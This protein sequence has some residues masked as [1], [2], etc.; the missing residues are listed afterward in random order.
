MQNINENEQASPV[1][2]DILFQEVNLAF[3][4]N[5]AKS[6]EMM[7]ITSENS[8]MQSMTIPEGNKIPP[9]ESTSSP[10]FPYPRRG[11]DPSRT[12][13]TVNGKA[14][15]QCIVTDKHS[16]DSH[17]DAITLSADTLSLAS[18]TSRSS[19][20]LRGVSFR[21]SRAATW[22]AA[23]LRKHQKSSDLSA[24]FNLLDQENKVCHL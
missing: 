11:T 2:D 18:K 1:S 21:R 9:V 20:F 17:G 10:L 13:T 12:T 23:K 3:Y 7:S 19:R 8:T 16:I 5:V 22:L 15:Y 14:S 24:A 6:S 4:T